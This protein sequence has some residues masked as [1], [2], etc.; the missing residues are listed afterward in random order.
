MITCLPPSVRADTPPVAFS[1][2]GQ[3]PEV[4]GNELTV[5][6]FALN[7]DLLAT[8]AQPT[9]LLTPLV[10]QSGLGGNFTVVVPANQLVTNETRNGALPIQVIATTSAG[11]QFIAVKSV[12]PSTLLSPEYNLNFT[13]AQQPRGT[14][15]MSAP[16]LVGPICQY[17][18][19]SKEEVAT[20]ALQVHV[21]NVLGAS[22]TLYMTNYQ[23][24][25]IDV[26]LQDTSGQF[27]VGG[28]VSINNS[29]ASGS[30]VTM[31]AGTL[32]W[33]FDNI[34]FAKE[35]GFGYCQYPTE[36]VPLSSVGDLF[37]IS[38]TKAPDANPY[39]GCLNDPNGYAVVNPGGDYWR[40]QGVGSVT[41]AAATAF[42]FSA[43][44]S[45]GFDN[46][47]KLEW[48]T[49]TTKTYV[50]GNGSPMTTGI[51]NTP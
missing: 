7:I 12:I 38:G 34:Y 49:S 19:S 48:A 4:V 40:S 2:K 1:I 36:V 46:N 47:V 23:N 39:G 18:I 22:E 35:T 32:D 3:I 44:A 43:S 24:G 50:C 51:Y 37:Q 30:R 17:Q 16:M 20:K 29:I 13:Q 33:L 26:G 11:E 42:G 5:S 41:Q 27:S 10:T 9:D 15:T 45:F 25:S 21:A 14:Q 31:K 6:V 28:S 8:N